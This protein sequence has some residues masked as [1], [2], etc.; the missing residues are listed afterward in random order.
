MHSIGWSRQGTSLD[1]A[2]IAGL[3]PS[4]GGSALKNLS[5]LLGVLL[6]TWQLRL[7]LAHP[8]PLLW[9]LKLRVESTSPPISTLT[10]LI[11]LPILALGNYCQHVITCPPSPH[12]KRPSI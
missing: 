3:Q 7:L 5:G 2:Q 4:Q 1:P 12:A 10:N 11:L 6:A 8:L 9:T